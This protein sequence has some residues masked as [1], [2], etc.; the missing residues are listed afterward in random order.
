MDSLLR[1][2]GNLLPYHLLSYGAL[3]GTELYQVGTPS[4]QHS[5]ELTSWT[6]LC[7]HQDL[8]PSP[9]DE[10]VHRPPKTNF[11]RLFCHTSWPD[12]PDSSDMSAIQYPFTTWKPLECWV[13]RSRW[14]DGMSELVSVRP[15]DNDYRVSEK[16]AT[17][18][19][20]LNSIYC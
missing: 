4:S 16:G 12:S 15:E 7:Q 20:S 13:S 18:Y 19:V 14:A 10:R 3:L 5:V 8:L 1:T 2:I 9:S 6:E 17:G 11:S